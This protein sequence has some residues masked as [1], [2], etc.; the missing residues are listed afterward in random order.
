MGFCRC[1]LKF[2]MVAF[3][4]PDMT[5]LRLAL[6]T[7]LLASSAATVGG[8]ALGV[9]PASAKTTP[10][11]AY[12]P[13]PDRRSITIGLQNRQL[14][15]TEVSTIAT[16]YSVVVFTKFHANWDAT[17]VQADTRRLKALNPN[18]KV[19]GYISTKFWF[20]ANNWGLTIN[21]AWFLTD[22][23][24][25]LIPKVDDGTGRT[26]ARYI[27]VSNPDYRTWILNVATTWM[28]AAP[29]D[30]IRFDAADPIADYGQHDIATWNSLLTPDKITAYNNGI[31]DL[32]TRAN[33]LLP[34]VLYN[35]ISPSDIRGP[36]RDLFQLDFTDGAMNEHFCI[37]GD[38]SRADLLADVTI[39]QQ[40]PT[41]SLQERAGVDPTVIGL[42]STNLL[43]RMCLG[44]FLMGWQPGSTHFNFGAGYDN[45]QLTQQ[46]AEV[47]L[48]LG[49]PISAMV[50]SGA[51]LDRRFEHGTAV[52]NTGTVDATVTMP[53]SSV[54][55]RDGVRKSVWRRGS[56]YTVHPGDAVFFLDASYIG[57][58]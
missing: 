32:L 26:D 22:Q 27:D 4:V 29:F 51:M 25:A 54:E 46:P 19:Y 15:D 39:M 55:F 48:T 12:Q 28:G 56:Q 9:S 14:R 7:V 23:T 3:D 16:N 18:L 40:Y 42:P 36:G 31:T 34:S 38:G 47:N 50:Q 21:P 58:G 49:N 37:N 24:G 2:V 30:G 44:V 41:K 52:V 13:Q 33:S 11:P 43:A 45:L 6:V 8:A 10:P 1:L 5:R 20:D 53:T 57:A 35:G 17:L